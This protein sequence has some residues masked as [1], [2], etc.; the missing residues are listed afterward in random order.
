M[1]HA[2]VAA[3]AALATLVVV[4]AIALIRRAR[5]G[6]AIVRGGASSTAL[7][8]LNERIEQ[9]SSDLESAIQRTEE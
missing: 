6:T 5:T 7:A 1:T 4:L 2:L 3:S 9:L 8:E